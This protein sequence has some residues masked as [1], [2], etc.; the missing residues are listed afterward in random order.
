MKIIPESRRNSK[1]ARSIEI[2]CDLFSKNK[3]GAEPLISLLNKIESI[4]KNYFSLDT[5]ISNKLLGSPHP[6]F[7]ERIQYISEE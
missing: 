1:Y 4:N 6:T 3:N 2:E 7:K 5:W